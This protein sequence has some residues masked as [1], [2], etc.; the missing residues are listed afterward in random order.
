MV[1]G[2]LLCL[3]RV[4]KASDVIEMANRMLNMEKAWFLSQIGLIP[5]C[6][7]DVLDEVRILWLMQGGELIIW[8]AKMEYLL[9]VAPA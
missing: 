6:D 9:V 8:V 3:A 2:R 1:G 7:D 5:D 4:A